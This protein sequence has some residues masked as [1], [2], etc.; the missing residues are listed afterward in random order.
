VLISTHLIT[1][2]EKT[3]DDVIFIAA[4]RIMLTSSVDDI[5]AEKGKSVD[6]LQ[7]GVQMLGK[8]MK[9]EF[10]A[11]GRIFLPVF[12]ALIAIS[13]VNRLLGFLD[14]NTP[15]VIG[16]VVSVI[17]MVG[18]AVITFVLIIQ[19]F[20]TN[21]LSSEGYLMM[22]LPVCTDRLILSK[23]FVAVI[24]TVVSY[25]VVGLSI[26]IMAVSGITFEGIGLAM[27]YFAEMIPFQSHQ[28]FILAL[29]ALVAV[30][31]G[32]FSN[33]LMLYACMSLSMLS[34]KY[35][36]LFAF[37]AYIVITTVLQII[38]TSGV[39]IAV[40]VGFSHGFERYLLS[41]TTFGQTQIIAW[42]MLAFSAALCALFYFITRYMLKS[43]LNLQ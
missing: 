39:A 27:R 35:R 42:L 21:F 16:T 30:V 14:L 9:Y 4:G 22:T 41:F 19:R 2:V 24:W 5:R 29:Q 13:I 31:L 33:I 10:M 37:G 38:V 1:D 8:L 12:G 20:W 26:M 7:G 15:A 23:L 36:G 17:L 34:N 18:I 28:T 6:E 43:R 11:M 32:M 40:A 3:I 25:F